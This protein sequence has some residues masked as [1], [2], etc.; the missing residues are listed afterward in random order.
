MSAENAA[1]LSAPSVPP[2]LR[3]LRLFLQHVKTEVR[4][5]F[6]VYIRGSI[7]GRLSALPSEV[8]LPLS[9]D[10]AQAIDEKAK[11]GGSPHFRMPDYL[12]PGLDVLLGSPENQTIWL[13]FVAPYDFLP[14]VPWEELLEPRLRAAVLRLPYLQALEFAADVFVRSAGTPTKVDKK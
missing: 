8:G 7:V 6:E 14:V 1:E 11:T 4:I 3:V 12:W 2:D 5:T 13:N 10:D 9:S